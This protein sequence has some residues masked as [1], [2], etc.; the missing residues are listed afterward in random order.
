MSVRTH[1]RG[2]AEGSPMDPTA[3]P[4]TI[5]EIVRNWPV[6]ISEATLRRAIL[7]GRLRASLVLG[8]WRVEPSAL[9][10]FLEKTGRRAQGRG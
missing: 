1:K 10:E 9:R 8:R 3:E 5:P 7:T 2:P 4:L 6:R